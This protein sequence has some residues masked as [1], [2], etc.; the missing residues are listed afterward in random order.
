MAR[1]LCSDAGPVA[2]IR[3]TRADAHNAIDEEMARALARA[4]R[5]CSEASGVHCVLVCADGP[6]FT[7]GG[8]L[9]DLGRDLDR[10]PERIESLTGIFHDSL[11]AI[12]ELECPVVCAVQGAVA[13]GG[14][15]LLWCAD[16]VIAADDVKLTPAFAAIGLSGDGGSSWYL[17]RLVGMRRALELMI[18]NRQLGA[19]EALALGLLSRVVPAAQLE[20]EA[21]A[22]AARLAAGPTLALA[23]TRRLLRESASLTLREALDAELRGM[24]EMADSED[25]RVGIAAF[26]RRERP[27]FEGR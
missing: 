27:L 20:P 9:R 1:V 21:L 3:L 24:R 23:R 25:A 22:T 14:L 16:I 7:V 4:V 2:T 8:D 10:L 18:E 15:G 5:A 6:S 19:E 12:A 17:P 13:G 11:A 26:A